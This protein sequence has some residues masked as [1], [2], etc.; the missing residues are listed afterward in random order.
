MGT[1]VRPA[2]TRG[3]RKWDALDYLEAAGGEMDYKEWANDLAPGR[4]T[5]FEAEVVEF[6]LR[7]KMIYVSG[8]RVMIMN[9]G[10]WAIGRGVEV[11][12]VTLSVA[13]P[14]TAPPVRPLAKNHMVRPVVSRPGA[15]DYARIPSLMG[16]QHVPHH[17]V[18]AVEASAE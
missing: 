14:R 17:S 5:R 13:A 6:L 1:R 9:A 16:G 11:Q 10:R 7:L 4:V 18:V 3:T 15:F 12:A 8:G 2:V